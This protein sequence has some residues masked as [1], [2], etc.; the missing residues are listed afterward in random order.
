MQ[1]LVKKSYF[2]KRFSVLEYKRLTCELNNCESDWIKPI[3]IKLS[4]FA[5]GYFKSMY[6][7]GTF[8]EKH[9]LVVI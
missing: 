6:I 3:I 7:L 9:T 2:V 5:I 8:P 1:N 4:P